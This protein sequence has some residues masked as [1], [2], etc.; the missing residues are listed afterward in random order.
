MTVLRAAILSSVLA[1]VSCSHVNAH[2]PSVEQTQEWLNTNV[3]LGSSASEAAA[4][5]RSHELEGYRVHGDFAIVHDVDYDYKTHKP[6]SAYGFMVGWIDYPP[7]GERF[8]GDLLLH[9][10][11][12]GARPQESGDQLEGRTSTVYGT[13][14]KGRAAKGRPT[15]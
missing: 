11:H 5:L 14:E 9:A 1:L 4:F 12:D 2:G 13:I 15:L 3:R 6:A 10:H 8:L 7:P